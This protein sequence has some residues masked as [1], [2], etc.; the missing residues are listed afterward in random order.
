MKFSE[1]TKADKDKVFKTRVEIPGGIIV[2]ILTM[3]RADYLVL[4]ALFVLY[5]LTYLVFFGIKNQENS[6][7][8]KGL[9]MD[10]VLLAG[11]YIVVTLGITPVIIKV[12]D[13]DFSEVLIY[14]IK[15]LSSF[16]LISLGWLVSVFVQER[17]V[18]HSVKWKLKALL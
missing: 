4:N 1:L 11:I 9:L 8:M 18:N 3:M 12:I 14:G 6:Y 7:L 2:V 15:T 5:I 13:H 17:L 16:V 10:G